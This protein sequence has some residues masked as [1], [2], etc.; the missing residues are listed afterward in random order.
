MALFQ[1]L[2]SKEMMYVG[3]VL[4][5]TASCTN[6]PTPTPTTGVGYPGVV[7]TPAPTTTAVSRGVLTGKAMCP[8][9]STQ[10]FKVSNPTGSPVSIQYWPSDGSVVAPATTIPAGGEFIIENAEGKSSNRWMLVYRNVGGNYVFDLAIAPREHH[11]LEP[12]REI[13]LMLK[14]LCN[15]GQTLRWTLSNRNATK[16]IEY[17]VESFSTF[18]SETPQNPTGT[19][20]AGATSVLS[21]HYPGWT[22][23]WPSQQKIFVYEKSGDEWV[24]VTDGFAPTMGCDH[25]RPRHRP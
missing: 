1:H 14:P 20:A 2:W 19:L 5:P 9:Q 16:P 17:R 6:I 8:T 22:S 7:P 24:Y 13:D 15:E 18:A 3:E 25:F 21:V 4:P 12:E 11:C 23:T 10:R